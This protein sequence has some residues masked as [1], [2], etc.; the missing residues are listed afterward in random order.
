MTSSRNGHARRALRQQ[1]IYKE[2]R[3]CAHCGSLEDLTID[4]VIP[5]AWRE[6]LPLIFDPLEFV[7]EYQEVKPGKWRNRRTYTYGLNFQV[8]C[9]DCN[10]A[11]GKVEWVLTGA[12]RENVIDTD[13]AQEIL[14]D[15]S[16]WSDTTSSRDE[17]QDRMI[18]GLHLDLITIR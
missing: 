4:H 6:Y 15:W 13:L 2:I 17:V 5:G 7:H 18:E 9:Y 11:K 12:L 16:D 10:H 14:I 8:L 1:W 3:P